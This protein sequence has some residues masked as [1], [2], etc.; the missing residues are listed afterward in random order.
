MDKMKRWS[1]L[2]NEVKVNNIF[3]FP[4]RQRLVKKKKRF[5]DGVF[6]TCLTK[7]HFPHL[8][9]FHLV[10]LKRREE[11]FS[12]L[13]LLFQHQQTL[14]EWLDLPKLFKWGTIPVTSFLCRFANCFLKSNWSHMFKTG[15][16]KIKNK[17][18]QFI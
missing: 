16:L 14:Q 11:A 7:S 4:K 13:L 6:S 17:N 10:M 12:E 2:Y 3:E 8:S 1:E 18:T 9:Y 5:L 15:I